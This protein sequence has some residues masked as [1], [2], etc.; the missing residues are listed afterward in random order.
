METVPS[1]G[2]LHKD[3][4]PGCRKFYSQ[5]CGLS[6]VLSAHTSS[7]L[8]P[9]AV[10]LEMQIGVPGPEQHK[11]RAVNAT[12]PGSRIHHVEGE[13]QALQTKPF[14]AEII[15]LQF[16]EICKVQFS[17]RRFQSL[18]CGVILHRGH[19]GHVLKDTSAAWPQSLWLWIVLGFSQ[20]CGSGEWL[21]QR[22]HSDF[23]AAA[24]GVCC[25]HAA[26]SSH[27]RVKY[28][29]EELKFTA[30]N[31]YNNRKHSQ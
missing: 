8:C 14:F 18:H 21:A 13:N 3:Q 29:R 31:I 17:V 25:V 16:A 19:K 10:P 4:W 22:N 1:R 9:P 6:P 5:P 12:S 11:P 15:K 30:R 26:R 24:P 7:S 20:F 23:S 28:L 2:H 27:R